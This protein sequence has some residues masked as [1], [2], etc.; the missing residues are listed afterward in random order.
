MNRRAGQRVIRKL[1]AAAAAGCAGLVAGPVDAGLVIDLRAVTLNGQP[2]PA[3]STAERVVVD[4]GDVVGI[5]VFARVSGTNAIDDE[6]FQSMLGVF[7]STTG[8]LLG[9]LS[10][11]T[12]A[13]F[14]GSGSQN[15]TPIDV[16]GDGDL[17][18][19]DIP[20]GGEQTAYWVARSNVTERGGTPVAT[21]PAAE[22]FL[23][24]TLT[25]TATGAVAPAS[26][27]FL[28]FIRRRNPGNPGSNGSA[29]SFWLEDGSG[30]ASVRNG[31]SPYVTDGLHIVAVPE[32]CGAAAAL[33]GV[34]ALRL[35]A[36]RRRAW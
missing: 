11:S 26:E 31:Q 13:P 18:I 34:A 14:N 27:T 35:L 16:D 19:G 28:D 20:N 9:H 24:G 6:G 30:T 10:A 12:V 1:A 22:E 15:G 25:W 2:L 3:G 36:R 4:A 8:G 29:Y 17:D 5:N 23:I 7:R 21:D 32:P 33:A